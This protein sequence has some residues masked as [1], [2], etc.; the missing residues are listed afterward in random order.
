MNKTIAFLTFERWHNKKNIGSSRI[1]A[2]WLINYWKEAEMLEQGKEYSVVIFQKVYWKDYVKVFKGIKILD[3]CDP[4]WYDTVPM[5]EIIDNC[6]AITTSTE[7]LAEAVRQF[8][9]KPVICIPDRVDLEKYEQ[10]KHKGKAKK[11]CWFGY[12]HNTKVLDVVIPTL[13]KYELELIVISDFRPPYSKADE[14][15]KYP[16]SIKEFNEQVLKCDFMI[17][18]ED[19]RPRGRFKSNNKTIISW[20]MGMPVAKN[21]KDLIRFLDENER[22]KEAD[23]RL[24]E[25]KE[26]WDVKS[27]VLA[28][29]KLIDDIKKEKNI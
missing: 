28:Y 11:V 8:T 5:K 1:R 7:T 2:K 4:D 22:Q 21:G 19:E 6:H 12:S 14:N 9:D 23:K 16:I 27:S 29:K 26:R 24:K 10:K 25:V 3:L 15:V 20:A 18:P 17:M 13:K